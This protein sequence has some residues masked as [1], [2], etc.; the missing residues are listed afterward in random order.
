MAKTTDIYFLT[1]LEAESPRPRCLQGW[2]LVR[3]LF[4]VV[5]S[6]SLCPHMAV[7]LCVPR[8][9]DLWVFL[10]I[11]TADYQIRVPSFLS[12]LTLIASLAILTPVLSH[13]GVKASTYGF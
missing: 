3:P 8:E 13:W 10:P 4:L 1:V 6:H 5:D 7:H 9:R 12:H 11:T 2:F